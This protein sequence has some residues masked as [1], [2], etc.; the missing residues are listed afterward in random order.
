MSEAIL[1]AAPPRL[2]FCAG[3]RHRHGGRAYGVCLVSGCACVAVVEVRSSASEKRQ[4]CR[5]AAK[6]F[7]ELSP[8]ELAVYQ[9]AAERSAESDL[10]LEEFASEAGL[11]VKLL[12]RARRS[13]RLASNGGG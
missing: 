6:A 7:A 1:A 2:R 9:R 10:L 11:D 4:L 13:L 12:W 8:A 5:L 3:C